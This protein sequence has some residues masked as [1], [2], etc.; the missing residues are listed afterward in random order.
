MFRG[1][2]N[3][4]SIIDKVKNMGKK[5]KEVKAKKK[6]G[7]NPDNFADYGDFMKAKKAKKKGK[8]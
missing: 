2:F 1:F 8:K 5:K 4:M 6:A 3:N 7:L